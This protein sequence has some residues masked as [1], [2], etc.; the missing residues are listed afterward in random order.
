MTRKKFKQ[1]DSIVSE[2]SWG[3]IFGGAVVIRVC[4]CL[5]VL[6][7]VCPSGGGFV[8]LPVCVCV[9]LCLCVCVPRVCVM[10]VCVCCVVSF[11]STL[12]LALSCEWYGVF[13]QCKHQRMPVVLQVH[14][15]GSGVFSPGGVP[16]RLVPAT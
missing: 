4:W 5:C 11:A 1:L 12:A 14:A 3:T 9:C 2:I 13:V 16:R 10:H 8:C 7:F 15:T 6:V